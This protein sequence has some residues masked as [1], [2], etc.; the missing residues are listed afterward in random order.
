MA[1]EGGPMSWN[2][3]LGKYFCTRFP[4]M[5][6]GPLA[7]FIAAAGLAPAP[8]GLLSEWTVAATLALILILQFRLWDDIADRELDRVLHPG[9]ILCQVHDIKPFLVTALVLSALCGVLLAWYHDQSARNAAYLL[10][11]AMLF[12]WYRLR[13][14]LTDQGL[15]NSMLV[16]FKYPV[17]AWLISSPDANPDTPLL[18]SC[19]LSVYLIFILFELLDDHKLGQRPGATSSLLA[20]LGFLL[21]VWVFIALW[22]RPHAGQL[23]WVAWSL[24]ITGTLLLGLSEI[25]MPGDRKAK[26]RG[27]GF[28]LLGLLAYSTVAIEG[29]P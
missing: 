15:L 7:I 16:L 18:F 23:P 9:R 19:L 27:S 14:A 13:P 21:C 1:I 10:L 11:C 6:F 20:S 24:I 22:T 25:S 26:R 3:A 29:S 8:P 2:K 12:A 28:F 5:Q 17:I 4:L